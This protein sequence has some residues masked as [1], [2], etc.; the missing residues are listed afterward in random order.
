MPNPL[1]F[2]AFA[3]VVGLSRGRVSQLVRE[4]LPLDAE[5]KIDPEAGRAWIAANIDPDRRR[6]G[7]RTKGA[8]RAKAAPSVTPL[9]PDN[10]LG[11]GATVARLRGHVLARQALML[12]LDLK[13]ATGEAVDRATV[14]KAVF[15]RA[16]LERD[17]WLSFASRAS[18]VLATEA[19]VD[20]GRSFPIL[21][22]I[23]RQH[24][25]ELAATPLRLEGGSSKVK[26]T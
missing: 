25:A 10:D 20:P 14:Q 16:R 8:K 15:D 6:G 4:G 23:V 13:R 11:S 19:G 21:D 2:K 7:G 12:D 5:R 26:I 3:A 24:L 1:T 9:T 18:A 17:S 22:R